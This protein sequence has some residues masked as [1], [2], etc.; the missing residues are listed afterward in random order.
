M[1]SSTMTSV[2]AADI[3]SGATTT[4]N[5]DSDPTA[6]TTLEELEGCQ[7]TETRHPIESLDEIC[8]FADE[9]RASVRRYV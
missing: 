5:I 1:C 4:R 2:S 3:T 8:K 6:E 9:I 7:K